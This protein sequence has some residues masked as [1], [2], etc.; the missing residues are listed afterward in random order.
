[1]LFSTERTIEQYFGV[2]F[3]AFS[4]AFGSK[5]APVILK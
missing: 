3:N 4:S 5:A 2:N 1:M